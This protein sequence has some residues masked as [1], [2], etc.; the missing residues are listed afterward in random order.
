M[1]QIGYRSLVM[2]EMENVLEGK[3]NYILGKMVI[4]NM[5]V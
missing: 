4:N 5:Y 2:R 3:L 1:L